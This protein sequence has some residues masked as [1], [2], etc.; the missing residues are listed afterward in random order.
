M[1]APTLN[2]ARA[3]LLT[4]G[5]GDD[6]RLQ[7]TLYVPLLKS[8][9]AEPWAR[10]TLLPSR[11]T[12]IHAEEIKHRRPALTIHI[13]PLSDNGVENDPDHCYSQFEQEIG[14]LQCDGFNSADIVVDFT[15]G[16]KAMSAAL[17]LAACRHD[18]ASLRYI[19]GNRD[20]RGM[21][22]PGTEDIV[23][24]SPAIAT[25]QKRLDTALRFT[26][27]G[28]FAGALAL[29][30]DGIPNAGGWP[31]KLASAVPAL[32]SALHFYAAWDRLDYRSAAA[33]VCPTAV[34][35]LEWTPLWP[36]PE[37][38]AWVAELAATAEPTDHVAMAARLRLLACD[39][40]A[41]GERRIRDRHYEDAVLRAY[42]VL[43]LVGQRRLF[44]HGLDSARLPPEHAAVR[45]LADKLA[46][47]GSAGFGKN[48][49]CTLTAGR[50]LVARLL[51]QLGD[52]LAKT[53]LN[54]DKQSGLP[55][56]SDRNYSVLIHG[57]QAVGP[58]DDAPLRAL[59]QKLEALLLEDAGDAAQAALMTARK[60]HVSIR[61]G[62]AS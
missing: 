62:S 33:I 5:T 1:N 52:E 41:N 26:E 54:F 2:R 23:A 35:L 38:T 20:L 10:I 48:K 59:Y 32:L 46:K 11:S 37:M 17:V 27:H 60:A 15:R 19:A 3:L 42:R 40:L 22:V 29:L 21:V 36:T 25:A 53:L 47:K 30:D 56:I 4:I 9:D 12:I 16:T 28:N 34:P 18:V 39:L 61:P 7:E 13:R 57:F 50:E 58:G 6:N 55:R 31:S 43:E 24:L 8:I 49:D 45:A 44:S 51:S 14:R